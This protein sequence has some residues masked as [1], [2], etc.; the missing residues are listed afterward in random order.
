MNEE[1]SRWRRA[2]KNHSLGNYAAA[3][4]D[5]TAL[6]SHQ[7]Y[8][9]RSAVRLI[10]INAPKRA[11]LKL[12]ELDVV[13]QTGIHRKGTIVRELLSS[14]PIRQEFDDSDPSVPFQHKYIKSSKNMVVVD[15]RIFDQRALQY[16]AR[17]RLNGANIIL[18]HL[19]DEAFLDLH[20]LY[21]LCRVV[22]RNYWSP[23]L[24]NRSNV[25]F[26]PLG[27]GAPIDH[28]I[29]LSDRPMAEREFLW[30]FVGDVNK[31]SRQGLV[32][33]FAD[34]S[35]NRIHLVG[36]FFD[37][38]KLGPVEYQSIVANSKFTLC[39]DGYDN[40]D[41]FRFWEAVEL[42]SIPVSIGRGEFRYFQNLLKSE[43]PFP[44]FSTWQDARN[45]IASTANNVEYL[46]LMQSSMVKWWL[47]YK[48]QLVEEFRQLCYK[49][50][51]E[52]FF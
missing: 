6:M 16:Y 18:I 46:N 7:E 9:L 47:A 23:T 3:R 13:W 49:V 52:S 42:G 34:L 19:A 30:N 14:I 20:E 43:L 51:S 8:N 41:T 28:E 22:Y 35:P 39:P 44:Q 40:H 45:Y 11:P 25:R 36:D 50:S 10:E 15:H 33:T 1:Y 27:V 12:D 32:E 31:K 48:F 4:E 26:F 2:E 37:P 5:Y 24:A 38:R 21:D 29:V 17:C